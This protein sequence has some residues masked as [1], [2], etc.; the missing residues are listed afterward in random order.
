M[1]YTH[2]YENMAEA[3]CKLSKSTESESG[4]TSKST[5]VGSVD[6]LSDGFR[7]SGRGFTG[8][9]CMRIHTDRCLAHLWDYC[10]KNVKGDDCAVTVIIK[11]W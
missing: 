5:S 2:T 4:A 6:V 3:C 7:V 1:A 9:L 11:V 10:K 8:R